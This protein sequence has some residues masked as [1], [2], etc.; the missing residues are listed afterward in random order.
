MIALHHYS[1][2]MIADGLSSS[3]FYQLFSTQGGYAG[4]AMFFFLSGY[5]L[6]ESES[7]MHLNIGEFIVKR[8]WKIYKAVLVINAIHYG[9]ILCW[10]YFNTGSWTAINWRLLFSIT[11]LDFHFWFI[12]VLFT[13]YIGFALATQIQKDKARN[14]ALFVGQFAIFAYWMLKEE[15]V[16]HLI[17]IPLFAVGIYVSLFKEKIAEM[18]KS[19]WLWIGLSISLGIVCYWTYQSHD[20]MPLHTAANVLMIAGLLWIV[21]KYE[22]TLGY[23]SFLGYISFPIYLIHWKV[24]HLSS[25]LGYIAPLWLYL[26]LT[27]YLAWLLQKTIEIS[28][29]KPIPSK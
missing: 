20:A 22:I 3:F 19:F 10:G 9:A 15:P 6:L 16:N 13:C 17:S 11:K 12:K 18:A 25:S 28:I 1:Q 14:I 27:I 26:L 7:K 21:S 5:G 29:N 8:F 2:Y 4:I 23:R 24:M